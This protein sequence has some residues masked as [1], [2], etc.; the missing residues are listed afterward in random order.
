MALALSQFE[1]TDTTHSA[2]Y[3]IV[4]IVLHWLMAVAL[5]GSFI[6]GDYMADLDFSPAK[7]KLVN[8]HKWAGITI[9]VFALIRLVWRLMNRPPA[10]VP[11]PT[12]QLWTSRITHWGMYA[13]FL[14]VPLAGWGFS[15][16]AGYPVKWFGVIPLPDFVPVDKALAQTLHDSHETLAWALAV[17][18]GLHFAAAMKH[19]FID[20]DG[21]LR[22]MLPSRGQ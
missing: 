5:V 8:W 16:A 13:L 7:L 17:L 12:W 21:L 3:S 10:A 4:A 9:L 20:R 14:L 18:V 11:M 22:R 2:R 6:V 15:S 19:H 1:M